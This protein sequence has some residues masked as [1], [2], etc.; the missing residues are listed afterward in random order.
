MGEVEDASAVR[1][2]LERE[3]L[4]AI[5]EPIQIVVPDQHHVARFGRALCRQRRTGQQQAHEQKRSVK[6]CAHGGVFYAVEDACRDESV[7]T[8]SMCGVWGNMSTGC[9]DSI[10]YPCR[11]IA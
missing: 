10:A 3:S 2:L 8:V 6:G 7:T 5:A 1:Q 11:T 9:I 4:A